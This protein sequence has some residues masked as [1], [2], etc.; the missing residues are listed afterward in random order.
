M[1]TSTLQLQQALY[2]LL[3]TDTLLLTLTTA[4]YDQVPE[5]AAFPYIVIG[6][7]SEV[8]LDSFAKMGRVAT[9]T[10][11]ILST[12]FGFKEALL[13]AD[14]LDALV[15]R[16]VFAF[17]TYASVYSLYKSLNATRM[18]DGITRKVDM[19]YDVFAETL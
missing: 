16:A 17:T 4:V 6:D 15:N 13:I 8:P 7:V 19:K 12:A 14:R 11:S 9:L 1:G 3:S 10:L 18:G 2:S 5:D